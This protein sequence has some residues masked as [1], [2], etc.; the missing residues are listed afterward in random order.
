M[1]ESIMKKIVGIMPLWDEEKES[2]WMLPGYPEG[3]EQAG[4]LPVI[5]P[6]TEDEREL[7]QLVSMCD[8]FLFTG[9][10]DVSPDLYGEVPLD[11]LGET[12]GKRDIME[13]IVL[14]KAMSTDK[15]ILGI[16]R[17]IQF[18][19]AA[20]G[21]TL[22]QDLPSQ[23]PSETEHHQPAPYDIPVHEVKIVMDSPLY[24]CLQAERLSV[25]SCHHQAV[26][27][28]APC[29]EP[30]AFSPDG[31]VEAAYLKDKK[32]LWAVQWHP[33]FSFRKDETSRRIFASVIKA[34]E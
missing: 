30:M 31:L 12:C 1:W 18:I 33:E 16:C 22:Y 21:G 10:Q 5:L 26:K 29:L 20:L 32:Y 7:E 19:N 24:R 17:G 14:K 8:G 13:S 4:G 2:I 15:P 27:K 23:H 34:M 6:L 9:G 25:N 11:Q 3:I 28:L